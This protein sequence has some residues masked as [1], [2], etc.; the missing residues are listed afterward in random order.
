MQPKYSFYSKQCFKPFNDCSQSL[1][2][3]TPFVSKEERTQMINKQ[4]RGFKVW[5]QNWSP[6]FCPF[7]AS[8]LL[9][10]FASSCRLQQ[11]PPHQQ[12][13]CVYRCRVIS[14]ATAHLLTGSWNYFQSYGEIGGTQ[15]LKSTLQGKWPMADSC[16]RAKLQRARENKVTGH[17]GVQELSREGEA[18]WEYGSQTMV[19]H[20]PQ[21]PTMFCPIRFCL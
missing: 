3:V 2:H 12:E 17:K 4:T 14:G 9:H 7:L 16:W 19:L 21:T 18:C 11:E 5:T 1:F 13:E 15:W 10:Q 6:G 20:L 8:F